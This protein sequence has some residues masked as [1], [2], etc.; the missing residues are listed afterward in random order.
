MARKG[1]NVGVSVG[2]VRELGRHDSALHRGAREERV[3]AWFKIIHVKSE[4]RRAKRSERVR[5]EE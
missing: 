4:K 5:S 1:A 2:R 3:C